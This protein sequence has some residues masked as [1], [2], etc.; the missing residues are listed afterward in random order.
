MLLGRVAG[1]AEQ[2]V[3]RGTAGSRRLPRVSRGKHSVGE[4][5]AS[6]SA[7]VRSQS[8]AVAFSPEARCHPACSPSQQAG[9]SSARTVSAVVAVAAHYVS[10]SPPR[11]GELGVDDAS[12]TSS[13]WFRLRKSAVKKQR[14]A[15][16]GPLV[17][18]GGDPP[19][20]HK[21]SRRC[22][23][24]LGG[25]SAL[26]KKCV[27]RAG[28]VG[29]NPAVL[30]WVSADS[31]KGFPLDCNTLCGSVMRRIVENTLEGPNL[32][33][34]ADGLPRLPPTTRSVRGRGGSHA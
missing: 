12:L 26:K 6:P 23:G 20:K 19:R 1:P 18:F 10:S 14:R 3:R 28:K 29:I 16:S 32:V 15:R 27:E 13:L 33:H 34:S 7:R 17:G 24:C 31:R 8:R 9:L 22:C 30:L 25:S 2:V 4:A 11:R 21:P 5:Q